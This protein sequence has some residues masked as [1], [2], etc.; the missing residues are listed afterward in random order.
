M[1]KPHKGNKDKEN[2]H[3]YTRFSDTVRGKRPEPP[4]TQEST[5]DRS[6][7]QEHGH[8]GPTSAGRWLSIPSKA[9]GELGEANPHPPQGKGA[10]PNH[11]HEGK[12]RKT[13]MS[14][15]SQGLGVFSGTG[16]LWISAMWGEPK[17]KG[18]HE[19]S[20][21]ELQLADQRAGL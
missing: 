4:S 3:A 20:V 9:Q 14:E 17:A 19:V 1:K 5:E 7:A 11:S 15:K 2:A 6:R 8:R 13:R 21:R 10:S 12:S 16:L 18:A